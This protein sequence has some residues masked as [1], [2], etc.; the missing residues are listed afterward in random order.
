M[1]K[2]PSLK[3][4]VRATSLLWSAILSAAGVSILCTLG[5][6]AVASSYRP[7]TLW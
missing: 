7:K 1:A 5:G 6:A 3:A 4:A 2:T